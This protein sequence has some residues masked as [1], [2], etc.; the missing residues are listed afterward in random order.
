M[1]PSELFDLLLLAGDLLPPLR[2]VPFRAPSASAALYPSAAPSAERW[3]RVTKSRRQIAQ[4]QLGVYEVVGAPPPR[5]PREIVHHDLSQV[6]TQAPQLAQLPSAAGQN[7]D[8]DV[9]TPE[10]TLSLRGP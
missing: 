3:G 8:V 1:I 4:R 6:V 9:E 5:R 10:G 7:S 2:S